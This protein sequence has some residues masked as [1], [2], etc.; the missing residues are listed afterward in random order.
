M[1]L[2]LPFTARA[3]ALQLRESAG[4][5]GTSLQTHAD[6]A[7]DCLSPKHAELWGRQHD[8]WRRGEYY[9]W[10]QSKR[11]GIVTARSAP[12]YVS[13][14]VRCRACVPCLK[15]RQ[16]IWVER[17]TLEVSRAQ[18]TWLG[19]LTATG[20]NQYGYEV[21]AASR[22]RDGGTAYA[23]LSAEDQFTEVCKEMGRDLTLFLKRLRRSGAKLRYLW[24]FEA[25][26]SGLPH[27]HGLVF[28]PVG[29]SPLKKKTF[30]SQWTSGFSHWR[31]LTD[32]RQITYPLKY[33]TKS[34]LFRIRASQRF[35]EMSLT[36]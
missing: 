32:A 31:L 29:F 23:T 17:A 4:A 5:E 7:G 26:K 3:L 1:T 14:Q 24:L 33:V 6:L 19:T 27:I 20:A 36:T 22:L 12:H 16:R 11:G 2:V 10:V 13:M 25:H 34:S 28:E 8:R 35:G 21:A 15:H 18:R 30:E 9:D